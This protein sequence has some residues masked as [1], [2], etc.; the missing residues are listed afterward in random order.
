MF[1]EKHNDS[2]NPL[3]I[4]ATLELIARRRAAESSDAAMLA[5]RVG[6]TPDA[7]QADVLRSTERQVAL[8]CSRQA[9]KS[10]VT[11]LLALHEA[12][13]RTGA[14][15]LLL[16]PSLRQSQELFLKVKQAYGALTGEI[17]QAR[18]ESA[19]RMHFSNDARIVAL[20]GKEATIRGY[21][22]VDLLVIDEAARVSDELY[23]AV[24][25]MLAVSGGRI[26][27]LSTPFGKR[28]FF[29]DVW[30]SGGA[31]WHR[32]KITA[33]DCPRIGREWLDDE[34]AQIGDFWFEQEYLCEF[35]DDVSA[36]FRYE[37][38]QNAI[39]EAVEPQWSIADALR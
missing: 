21:S 33:Y 12:L 19:L 32:T 8:L 15:I 4:Q 31:G 29:F 17:V 39:V 14:L 5:A 30:N 1:Y 36:V 26:V 35:K 16:S 25:P 23:Q 11:S 37:D 10:T 2:S 7:W 9:G 27:L 6:I 13:H 34:R 22:G 28:G 20:P 3:L 18:E 38:I 24:R